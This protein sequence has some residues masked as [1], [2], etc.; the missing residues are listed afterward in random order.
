MKAIAFDSVLGHHDGPSAD[1]PCGCYFRTIGYLG[2]ECTN[3][4]TASHM[5]NFRI[6]LKFLSYSMF[7]SILSPC[8][9]HEV[10][11]HHR[12][13]HIHDFFYIH[14][15]YMC[16]HKCILAL[17][18]SWR[19]LSRGINFMT[20]PSNLARTTLIPTLLTFKCISNSQVQS[21]YDLEARSGFSTPVLRR[22]MS[23]C[24][25]ILSIMDES[26]Q[27]A[28]LAV[29]VNPTGMLNAS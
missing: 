2:A 22:R 25:D 29:V 28:Y 6:I 19:P 27:S 7:L 4:T 23:R 18:L 16:S 26:I 13:S 9:Y 10:S 1:P 20:S 3:F 14:V 5:W 15:S 8:I 11:I 12:H 17:N 24:H 21:R